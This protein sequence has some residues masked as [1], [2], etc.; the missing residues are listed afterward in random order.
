MH[1]FASCFVRLESKRSESWTQFEFRLKSDPTRKC[2]SRG[3]V[4]P[5][6]IDRTP[7]D[8]MRATFPTGTSRAENFAPC[9]SSPNRSI[10]LTLADGDEIKLVIRGRS[11]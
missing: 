3:V 8:L 5:F 10:F 6:S 1:I 7:Y 11:G 9:R 4:L 2:S